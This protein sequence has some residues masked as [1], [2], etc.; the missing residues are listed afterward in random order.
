MLDLRK[1]SNHLP[2][3]AILFVIV[4]H[5]DCL[6]Q[7]CYV[8]RPTAQCHHGSGLRKPVCLS[9][10]LVTMLTLYLCRADPDHLIGN[11]CYCYSNNS[12]SP[13]SVHP[14][15]ANCSQ[16]VISTS[17]ITPTV[18]KPSVDS[19]PVLEKETL[20]RSWMQYALG[21][22]SKLLY[23]IYLRIYIRVN[24][25][26]HK[27]HFPV[28]NP[29]GVFNTKPCRLLSQSTFNWCKSPTKLNNLSQR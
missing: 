18:T 27:S 14:S 9:N 23:S 10:S 28:S 24:L 22:Y 20:G 11:Y 7:V 21:Y 6:N 25:S 26:F 17:P 3:K 16:V 8:A 2:S 12:M 29:G 13:E 19:F 4:E 5:Y 15:L 1:R